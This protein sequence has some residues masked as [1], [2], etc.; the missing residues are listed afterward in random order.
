MN[1]IFHRITK[2]MYVCFYLIFF[3]RKKGQ[4]VFMYKKTKHSDLL[5]VFF[6][7]FG[8]KQ[9]KGGYNYIWSTRKMKANKLWIRDRFGYY[10]V[11]S[12]YFGTNFPNKSF[13]REIIDIISQHSLNKK[14][15]F[16]GTSKGGSAALFYGLLMNADHIIIGSPQYFIGDYLKQNNYHIKIAESICPSGNRTMLLNSILKETICNKTFT[17]DINLLFSSNEGSYKDHLEPLIFDLKKFNLSV[18]DAQYSSHNQVAYY[19]PNYLMAVF[20]NKK[21]VNNG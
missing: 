21:G 11:G 12:Y 10:G 1:N 18:Y 8:E 16:C 7:A 14:L 6:S 13:Q 20:N 3:Q 9:R 17:G 19:Y 4:Q 15:F 5:I 2:K